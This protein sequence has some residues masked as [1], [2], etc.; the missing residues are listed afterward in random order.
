MEEHVFTSEVVKDLFC[1]GNS[2][3]DQRLCLCETNRLLKAA[4]CMQ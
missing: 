2:H 1:C 4:V 3:L